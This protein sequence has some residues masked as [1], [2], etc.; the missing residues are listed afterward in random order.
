MCPKRGCLDCN[1]KATRPRPLREFHA[2]LNF[3]GRK[4]SEEVIVR[5]SVEF[6]LGHFP[7]EPA[8][9]QLSMANLAKPRSPY[10]SIELI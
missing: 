9:L 4:V 1:A 6:P 8:T 10:S 5:R 3:L 2:L 7:Y